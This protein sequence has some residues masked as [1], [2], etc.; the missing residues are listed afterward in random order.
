MMFGVV[1]NENIDV[2]RVVIDKVLVEYFYVL[3]DFVFF[4]EV[5][6]LNDSFV[7]FI[8]CLFCY[9]EYYFDICFLVFE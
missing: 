2:V 7:D 1:Y 9:G 5:F 3:K 4:V 8:V 6:I